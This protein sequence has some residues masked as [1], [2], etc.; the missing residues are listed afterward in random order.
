MGWLLSPMVFTKLMRTVISFLRHPELLQASYR[1]LPI[2]EV[3]RALGPTFI[4]MYLDDLLALLAT[5]EDGV[6][7]ATALFDLFARLGIRCQRTKSQADP[8]AQLKHLGFLVDV[9][10]RQLLLCQR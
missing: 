4:S 1:W 6:K 3:L 2:F 7:L 10:G 8:V 9:P 5:L